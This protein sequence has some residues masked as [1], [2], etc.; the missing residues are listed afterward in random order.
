MIK[1]LLFITLGFLAVKKITAQAVDEY[2]MKGNEL[3]RQQKY[4]E[5][6][7]E[8][9]TVLQKFPDNKIAIYNLASTK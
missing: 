1:Q 2:I 6:E 7:K 9:T 3:Y 4:A 8:Y 5:A